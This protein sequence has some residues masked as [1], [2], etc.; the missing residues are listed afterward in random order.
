MALS[1]R[2]SFSALGI[3]FPCS[4]PHVVSA[5]VSREL[6]TLLAE[7]S[8]QLAASRRNVHRSV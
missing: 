8:L 2:S 7:S 4:Y 3:A 1:S 6:P 5:A